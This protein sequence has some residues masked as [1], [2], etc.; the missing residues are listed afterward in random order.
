[1]TGPR[2]LLVEDEESIA[3]PFGEALEREGFRPVVAATA[4]DAL[5]RLFD[6]L[7]RVESSRTRAAG[8]S[9]LGLAIARSIAEAHGG[10]ID[11]SHSALGGLRILVQLPLGDAE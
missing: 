11:A 6:R 3:V 2:I 4:A 1:M 10:H 8:G 5:P 7:Y 9:G